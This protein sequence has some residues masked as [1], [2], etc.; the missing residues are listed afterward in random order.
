MNNKTIK[1]LN[2]VPKFSLEKYRKIILFKASQR[3]LRELD[4]ILMNYIKNA[5]LDKQKLFKMENLM[6]G[7]ESIDLLSFILKKEE[8]PTDLKENDLF[9][10]IIKFTENKKIFRSHSFLVI[11]K[12]KKN[13]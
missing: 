10:E 11:T 1:L 7:Y 5:N 4:L 6:N 13:R 9:K 2:K 8:P 12:N 3:G